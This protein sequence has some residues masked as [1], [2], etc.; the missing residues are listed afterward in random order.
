M[1]K[2]IN[3]QF[4]RTH[5]LLIARIFMGALFV[6]SGFMKL[7]GG[8]EDTAMYIES[9]GIPAATLLAW[10]AAI[11]E[12]VA[13]AMLILG[14]YFKEA[15]LTLAVFVFIISFPFHGPATWEVDPMQ[16]TAFLKN[17]AIVA[18]LLFMAAHGAGQTWSLK[19]KSF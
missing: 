9:A 14:Y 3:H 10:A 7:N 13:G 16:Q 15:A 2:I 1:D 19:L 18:G 6:Y 12:L 8:I 5:A 4:W 17:M 11:I